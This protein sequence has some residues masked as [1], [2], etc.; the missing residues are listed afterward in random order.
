MVEGMRQTQK[1]TGGAFAPPAGAS[2]SKW[3]RLELNQ[4][5]LAGTR[6]STLR[7]CQFRHEPEVRRLGQSTA[8]PQL[9]GLGRISKFTRPM[10]AVQ[11]KG[12]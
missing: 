7:V 5:A 6:P 8:R 1:H 3:A 2:T 10:A 4:H 11:A 9:L 12:P